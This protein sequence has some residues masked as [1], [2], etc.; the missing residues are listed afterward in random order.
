MQKISIIL[1]FSIF[2]L[3]VSCACDMTEPADNSCGTT[4]SYD[5]GIKEI[6][7]V[8][9][10]YAG[11]HNGAG[12]GPGDYSTYQ[13]LVGI[14]NS[15][16]FSNRVFE[17]KDNPAIGM[18]PDNAVGGP[19]DLTDAELTILMEWVES[20]YP[21]KENSIAATYDESIKV[22]IDAGCAY[23]GCHDGQRGIGN[24]SNYQGIQDIILSGSFFERVVEI[25]ED[26]V[27][28]MPPARS[29]DFGGAPR[30]SDE[31]FELVLCWIENGYPE[32]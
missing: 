3:M 25:R 29:V 11:C 9:C 13:G 31:E 15:G 27:Q 20:G 10:A 23:S 2:L 30:L 5:K 26:P 22:I 17:L 14:L 7:D 19:T 4:M 32:N 6:I 16:S 28:G 21:E 8:S 18:P 12:L 24:Y 1:Y